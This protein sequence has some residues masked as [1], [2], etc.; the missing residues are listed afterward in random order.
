MQ[1]PVAVLATALGASLLLLNGCA[2]RRQPELGQVPLGIPVEGRV[3][4]PDGSGATG[5]TVRA[6]TVCPGRTIHLTTTAV[7]GDDGRFSIDSFDS[8]CEKV[9][10]S[11]SYEDEFWLDTDRL[12]TGR[13]KGPII[14]VGESGPVGPIVVQLG[15]RGGVVELSVFDEDTQRFIYGALSIHSIDHDAIIM[16]TATGDR[17]EAHSILLPIGEYEVRL[18]R[19]HCGKKT[20]FTADEPTVRFFI[21]EG[22][23]TAAQ[24]SVSVTALDTKPSYDNWEAKRCT[25]Q[26]ARKR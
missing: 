9:E 13:Q 7:A 6:T 15:E 3:I 20:Y 5:A 18:S 16:G 2:H 19:F 23:R 11:A 21:E 25:P 8:T 4:Y 24:I 1:H 12:R 14:E 22:A 26:R 10:F 17:G